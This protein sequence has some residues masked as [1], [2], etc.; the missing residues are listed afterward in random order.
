MPLERQPNSGA[1]QTPPKS[2]NGENTMKTI[3]KY[4]SVLTAAI[5]ALSTGLAKADAFTLNGTGLDPNVVATNVT[6][7]MGGYVPM[8]ITIVV[9]LSVLVW[10][11]HLVLRRG[12]SV[13]R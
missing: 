10:V 8:I 12:S 9:G 3:S 4:A 1:V 2:S 7:Q 11:V 5:I 13:A 6:T